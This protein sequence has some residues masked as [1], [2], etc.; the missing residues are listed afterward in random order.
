MTNLKAAREL[1][2]YSQKQLGAKI[3]VSQNAIS[4]YETGYRI[5]DAQTICRVCDVLHCTADYLLDRSTIARPGLT[6]EEE[7]LLT[8]YRAAS[9]RDRELVQL[10]LKPYKEK[11]SREAI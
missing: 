11:D 9:S 8:A 10:A 1:R 2:G 4:G 5:M 3:G 7:E 6:T